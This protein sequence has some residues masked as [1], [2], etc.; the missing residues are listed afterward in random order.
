MKILVVDNDFATLRSVKNHLEREKWKVEVS[1]TYEKAKTLIL[2]EEYDAII[3]DY[4]LTSD[5]HGKQGL[6]L[7]KEI[8]DAGIQTPVIFLT[9]KKIGEITPWDALNVGGDDFIRKPWRSKELIARVYAVVRRGFKCDQNSTNILKQGKF[10][11][12]LKLKKLKVGEKEI[13]LGNIL[14]VI[15]ERFLKKPN[16]LHSYEDLIQH[17]W[18]S[19]GD[20][21]YSRDQLN[22]LRVHI[23][24]LKKELGERGSKHIRTIHRTGYVWETGRKQGAGSR[25]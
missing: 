22:K 7:V 10:C 2:T 17:V 25:K 24:H 8:R 9:G 19:S 5:E 15:L 4:H 1:D 23:A 18:G 21:S 3:C 11:L 6:D 13:I 12:D 14:A 20:T 16:V